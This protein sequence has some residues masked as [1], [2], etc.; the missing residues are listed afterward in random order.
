RRVADAVERAGQ[1]LRLVDLESQDFLPVELQHE[2]VGLRR[3]AEQVGID[4][5]QELARRLAARLVRAALISDGRG[6]VVVGCG[7]RGCERQGENHALHWSKY[8]R[9]DTTA[10]TT[11]RRSGSFASRVDWKWSSSTELGSRAR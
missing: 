9:D 3:A 6:I 1:D 10:R 4:R 8:S 11:P 7:A 5:A 2:V